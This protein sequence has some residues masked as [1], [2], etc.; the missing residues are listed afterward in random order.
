MTPGKIRV[1]IG[2]AAA[3][4]L[5]DYKQD[6]EPTTAY[7]M[8]Y[9]EGSCI[10][11]C[12]FCA[13][14]RESASERSLLSRV[15]WPVFETERMLRGLREQS[16]PITRICLQVINYPGFLDDVL[17]L[18]KAIKETTSLPVSLDTC[19]VAEDDLE[20]LK[21]AGVERISIPLDAAT[22]GLFDEVKGRS[23]K[24]PY[25]WESHMETLRRALEVFGPG[26]VMTNLIVGLGETEEEAVKLI[27]R[28]MDMNV[29][30]V[31]FAFTPLPKTRLS[32]RP[33]PPLDSYR[34]I[35]LARYIIVECM[36]RYEDMGFDG[37]GKLTG[38]GDIDV[39]RAIG[40]GEPFRT[41]GCPGCNRPFFNERPSGP[42]Y[43]YPRA[44]TP[45]ELE[46]EARLI[47]V[48]LNE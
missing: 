28:L 17:A 5:T 25:L 4:G 10:A 47:G 42:F 3:L 16:G 20:R 11:N 29:R 35:Q 44:L 22:P 23:A 8:T 12:A 38:F 24:G 34:Q 39:K 26:N 14:A 6:V 37:D 41:T 19:P 27:Q 32:K 46:R 33:Q 7:L 36:G 9:T 13:Q 21:S 1:S 30:A 48:D 43:N 45:E 2:T 18:L 15:M 40:D 31:L